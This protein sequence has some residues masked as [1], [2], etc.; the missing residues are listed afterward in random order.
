[1]LLVLEK[2]AV[3]SLD[4]MFGVHVEDRRTLGPFNHSRSGRGRSEWG[5]QARSSLRPGSAG[6]AEVRVGSGRAF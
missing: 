2:V 1:M 6:C 5:A 4:V 3:C